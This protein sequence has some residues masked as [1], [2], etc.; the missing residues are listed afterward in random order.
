MSD[1]D[2]PLKSLLE[3]GERLCALR[4]D[5][6]QTLNDLTALMM[7]ARMNGQGLHVSFVMAEQCVARMR[8]AVETGK[9]PDQMLEN[10]AIFEPVL[11]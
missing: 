7:I 3:E 5:C 8:V 4:P 2:A 9:Y 11:A 6:H 1:L 10:A